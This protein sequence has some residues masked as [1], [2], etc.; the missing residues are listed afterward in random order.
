MKSLRLIALLFCLLPLLAGHAWAQSNTCVNGTGGTCGVAFTGNPLGAGYNLSGGRLFIPAASSL[1]TNTGSLSVAYSITTTAFSGSTTQIVL[2]TRAPNAATQG[3]ISFYSFN[4]NIDFRFQGSTGAGTANSISGFCNNAGHV[5]T[6]ARLVNDGNRHGICQVWSPGQTAMY[7]DGYLWGLNT[8]PSTY[9]PGTGFWVFG[10]AANESKLLQDFRVYSVALTPA[11]CALLSNMAKNNLVPSSGPLTQN[12]LVYLPMGG[13]FP[14]TSGGCPGDSGNVPENNAITS[15]TPI[16]TITAPTSGATLTGVVA[17]SGTCSD[18]VACNGATFTIGGNTI[19]T[20]TGAGPYSTTFNSALL[21]DGSYT[22]AMNVTNVAGTPNSTSEPVTSS[23]GGIPPATYFINTAANGA[24]DGNDGLTK[25][26]SGGHGPWLTPNHNVRCGDKVKA[27]PASYTTANGQ[28]FSVGA[29]GTVFSCPTSGGLYVAQLICDGSFLEDC[30]IST[31]GSGISVGSPDQSNWQVLGF[32]F[33]NANS[34]GT[35]GSANP[36]AATVPNHLLFVGNYYDGCDAGA[37]GNDYTAWIGNLFYG[38][39]TSTG[40]SGGNCFSAISIFQPTNTNPSDTGTHNIIAGNFFINNGA[41]P[42]CLDGEAV[43]L[44]SWLANNYSAQFDFEQNLCIGNFS[45]CI[46]PFNM[47]THSF[48]YVFINGNTGWGDGVAVGTGGQFEVQWG[49]TQS[50]CVSL[51]NDI[52]VA[53]AAAVCK[54]SGGCPPNATTPIYAIGSFGGTGHTTI[55]TTY[56]Y[57]T[58]AAQYLQTSGTAPTQSGNTNA[59]PG[60]ANPQPVAS[61]PD[62]SA[63][64]TPIACVAAI[65]ANFVPSG[66]AAALGYQPPG[67]CNTNAL[68]PTWIYGAVP[69]GLLTKPCGA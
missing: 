21:T 54:N 2:D 3:I 13:S 63:S 52:F 69:S 66:G 37:G 4:E 36:N 9:V 10:D 33:Q 15:S 40:V 56:F 30:T 7:V 47:P 20:F 28:D 43:I 65:R 34:F 27:E 55:T 39:A 24:S 45:M 5:C 26:P 49:D 68:Y 32:H 17:V 41:H 61:R 18:T 16:A 60:F 42:G 59:D 1:N 53:T 23:N 57:N 44:D 22:L 62:C 67:A 29:W 48:Q 14:C 35:C 8:R 6:D 50:C 64:A 38:N 31:A 51:T 11:Q 12:L 46:E 19:G 25:T 58:A